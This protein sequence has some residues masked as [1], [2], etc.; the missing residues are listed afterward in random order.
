MRQVKVDYE[1]EI[2]TIN[3]EIDQLVQVQKRGYAKLAFW[4]FDAYI[5]N[6]LLKSV[7][8]EVEYEN[9]INIE[10]FDYELMD[11]CLAKYGM[12]CTEVYS[13]L[14]SDDCKFVLNAS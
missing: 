7:I 8:K 11:D 14:S 5:N 4:C 13:I 1:D 2:K 10:N 9:T 3:S 6:G 12:E